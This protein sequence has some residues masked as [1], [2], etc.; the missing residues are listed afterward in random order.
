MASYLEWLQDLPFSMWI[1]GSE[2]LLSFPLVLFLHSIGM[3]ISAGSAYVVCMRLVGV[4]RPLPV[5]SLRVFF[6]IF[7]GGFFL[8]L[9][10]G[11]ILFAAHATTTGYVPMYYAK[12]ALIAVG[13]M[14]S[15]PIRTFVDG[16][17]SDGIIPGRIKGLAVLSLL[18]WT[19]VITTGRLIAYVS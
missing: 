2:S 14:L 5:S 15:V 6:K 4:G 12:L 13:M 9:V 7:W 19:G 8:N 18:V 11:S 16:E 17:T 3:G 1:A 10:T